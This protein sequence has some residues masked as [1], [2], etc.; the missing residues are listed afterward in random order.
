MV[1]QLVAPAVQRR[2]VCTS[3]TPPSDVR[4]RAVAA[5]SSTA[6]GAAGASGAEPTAKVAASLPAAVS[7]PLASPALAA[8]AIRVD[9]RVGPA[10]G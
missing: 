2:S 5:P 1:A 6:N 3:T 4:G 10:R 7:R 9:F 8:F